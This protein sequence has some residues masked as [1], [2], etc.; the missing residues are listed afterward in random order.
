MERLNMKKMMIV[1]LGVTLLG[2]MVGCGQKAIQQPVTETSKTEVVTSTSSE[3]NSSSQKETTNGTSKVNVMSVE[4]VIAQ[5]QKTYPDSDITSIQLENERRGFVYKVEGVDDNKEYEIKID[6]VTKEVYQDKSENLDK[7]EKNGI[8]REEDKLD[9]EGILSIDEATK[10]AEEEAGTGQAIE[11][12]LDRELNVT[13]WEVTVKDGN[14]KVQ[15]KLDGKTGE[16]LATE[17]DD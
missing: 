11:W 2:V 4:D 14:N 3:T 9:L 17:I 8:K 16:V 1:G 15:V 13:Y 10:I 12:D 6:A 5:Y 7:D